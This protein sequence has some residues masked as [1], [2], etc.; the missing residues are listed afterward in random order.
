M[1]ASTKNQVD[2][3]QQTEDN[4]RNAQSIDGD[5]RIGLAQKGDFYNQ[6]C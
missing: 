1:L 6:Q 4:N 3:Y 5:K 2:Q